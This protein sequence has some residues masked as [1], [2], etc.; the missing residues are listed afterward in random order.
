MSKFKIIFTTGIAM[1][2]MFF[3]SGNLVFPLRLGVVNGDQYLLSSIGF[4]ITGVAMPFLGLFSVMLYNGDRKKYFGLLGKWEPF[5][6]T[7]IMLLLLGPFGVV[8]RCIIVAYGG[9][10]TLYP[11]L[12]LVGFSIFF[13]S[14]ML[15]IIWE[16]N[17]IV[18]I[19]GKLLGPIKITTIIAVIIAGFIVAP[20]IPHGSYNAEPFLQGIFEGYQTMDL[21]AAFF[22]SVTIVEYLNRVVINKNDVLKISLASG[23]VGATLIA[24]I[25]LCLTTLGAHYS[26]DL[27]N[28]GPEQ[29]LAT[30]ANIS[31]GK[32]AALIFAITMFLA[33]LTTAATLSRLFAE[34]LSGD[35]SGGRISW[36]V[37]SLITIGVSFLLSLTG[38][39]TIAGILGSALTYIYPALVVLVI[40]SLFAKYANFKYT[41]LAFW[42]AIFV[43][44]F[45][46]YFTMPN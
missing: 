28:L 15:L 43:A 23:M 31:L 34:F 42:A 24:G 7:A 35:V 29:Y 20:E 8:P 12:S 11:S 1:F 39:T 40:S 6:L 5:V 38:F 32:Y 13:S 27:S 22:F 17:S 37:S 30:I 2:A 16:K 41:R 36:R 18:P 10:S 9:I 3:G 4:I 44:F 25:Y 33:C 14:L 19:I 26:K 21:A 45:C 46:D